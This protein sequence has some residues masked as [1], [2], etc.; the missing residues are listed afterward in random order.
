MFQLP[1]R[2]TV[3]LLSMFQRPNPGRSDPRARRLRTAADED[4]Q[5]PAC[6]WFDSS[7][8]LERGLLVCEHA[9]HTAA[10]VMAQAPLADWLDFQL[11]NWHPDETWP[12]AGVRSQ[13]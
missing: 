2:L 9:E 1:S 10:A 13:A 5:P 7:H 8:E 6:G 4:Q 12:Q 11:R 3:C